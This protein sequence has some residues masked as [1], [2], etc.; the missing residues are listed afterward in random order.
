MTIFRKNQRAG[1]TGIKYGDATHVLENIWKVQY[2]LDKL[3]QRTICQF[4]NT[5]SQINQAVDAEVT[6]IYR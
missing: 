3:F 4:L 6:R 2:F 5:F 1:T